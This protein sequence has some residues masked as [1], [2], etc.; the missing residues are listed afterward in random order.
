MELPKRVY[1]T[2]Q[3]YGYVNPMHIIDL[4]DVTSKIA[5]NYCSGPL[6]QA[7]KFAEDSLDVCHVSQPN[8]FESLNPLH[9]GTTSHL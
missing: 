6:H 5:D 7:G 8:A 3:P 1:T 4:P 2:T 9:E